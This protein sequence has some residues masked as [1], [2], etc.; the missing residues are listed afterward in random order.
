MARHHHHYPARG[1]T[2]G[3]S[4]NRGNVYRNKFA[5]VMR[6]YKHHTLHSGSKRGKEVRNPRQAKA[7]AASEARRA[8]EG[9]Y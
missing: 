8:V 9:H 3:P 1:R 6:E 4:R 5:R 7:I 2:I